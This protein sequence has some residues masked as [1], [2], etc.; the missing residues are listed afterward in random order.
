LHGLLAN[1]ELS[2]IEIDQL[3]KWMEEHE[4]LKGTYPLHSRNY[5]VGISIADIKYIGARL[6]GTDK[7]ILLNTYGHMSKRSERINNEKINNFMS[8]W[9]EKIE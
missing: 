8:S 4:F 6:G 7:S 1:N 9:L 5:S 2:E 3:A